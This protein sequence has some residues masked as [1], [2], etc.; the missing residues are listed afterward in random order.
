LSEKPKNFSVLT[1][2]DIL[3]YTNVVNGGAGGIL[4]ASHLC[5]DVFLDVFRM[6]KENDHQTAFQRWR[7]IDM[8]I[9][10]LFKEP[11]PSPIKYCLQRLDLIRSSE[12]RLPLTSISNELMKELDQSYIK[13]MKEG[14]IV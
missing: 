3:F 7:E 11:N 14:G 6:V 13:K 5:T 9:P 2:E 8:M 12:V 10:L 4:A 1:G